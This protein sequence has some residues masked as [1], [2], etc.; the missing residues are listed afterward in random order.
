MTEEGVSKVKNTFEERSNL[1]NK[2]KEKHRSSVTCETVVNDL[3][4]I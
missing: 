2:E 1:K 3:I 4:Q